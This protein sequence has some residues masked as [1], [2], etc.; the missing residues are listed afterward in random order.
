MPAM[1]TPTPPTIDDVLDFWFG[2]LDAHGL[3]DGEHRQRWF[4]KDPG[5]DATIRERFGALREAVL[6]GERD[7]WL[8]SPRGVLASIIALDQF[9]RNMFRGAPAMYEADDRAIELTLT[10]L[11]RGWE[12]ELPTHHRTFALMPLM[13]SERIEQQDRCV[14]GFEALRDSREG[15][16]RDQVANNLRYAVGHRDIVAR[17]GR[18]P[19]RNEILGRTSTTDE[20]AFLEKPGSSF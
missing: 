9:S 15:V 19:H 7:G 2:E 18:F 12:G 10:L 5:F 6:A 13:H 16:A 20:E 14:A 1:S 11:D 3:A 4:R 17:F 8:D